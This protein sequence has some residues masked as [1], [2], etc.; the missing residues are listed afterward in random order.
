MKQGLKVFNSSRVKERKMVF[1]DVVIGPLALGKQL[2]GNGM[3]KFLNLI[4]RKFEL[5]YK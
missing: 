1:G 2:T 3:F 4:G 5:L